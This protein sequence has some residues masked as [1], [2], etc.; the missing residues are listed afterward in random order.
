MSKDGDC[1]LSRK[2]MYGLQHPRG[3]GDSFEELNQRIHC[4]R[5]VHAFNIPV[6]ETNDGAA[7]AAPDVSVRLKAEYIERTN[8]RGRGTVR[9]G[10]CGRV[11]LAR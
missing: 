11:M 7:G 3:L 8:G 4:N 1:R 2:E 9:D 6:S 5:A 10:I